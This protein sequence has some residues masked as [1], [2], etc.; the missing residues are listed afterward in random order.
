MEFVDRRS[1]VTRVKLE[2]AWK[3]DTKG[4]HVVRWRGKS[5]YVPSLT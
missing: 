1:N 5:Q 4:R 2:A 3:M